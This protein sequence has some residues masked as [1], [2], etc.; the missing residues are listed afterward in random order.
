LAQLWTAYVCFVSNPTRTDPSISPYWILAISLA[1]ISFAGPLVRLSSADPVAIAVWRLGLALIVVAG[2]LFGSGQWRELRR[3]TARQLT[4]AAIGGVSLALHFWAWNASIHLTTIA[5]SVTLVSLQPAVVAV[6]SAVLI[7][8]V[9]S[10]QQSAGI[11]IAIVGALIVAVPDLTSGLAPAGNRPLLG[12]LLALSAAL[13]AALYYT[14]GRHLRMGLGLWSYVGVVYSAA[15]LTLLGIAL[16]RGLHL[17]PQPPREILIFAGLALAPT[18]LGHTG[19]N[20]ALKLLPAF[21]VN[22]TVLGEPVG[23]TLLGAIIPSIRE[24]PT[25]TTFAGGAII[26]AGVIIAARR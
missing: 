1:G 8:E 17:A 18:L 22:L 21:V 6:I 26:L 10:R 3:I 13:T 12:N 16:M 25:A 11:A 4:W 24:I 19:M 9:P 14:I 5:A 2:F 15:F 23:A 20:W 7:R